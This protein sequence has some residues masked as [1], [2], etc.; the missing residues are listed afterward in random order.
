MFFQKRGRLSNNLK[1]YYNN[2]EIEI[3]SKFTYLGIVSST[4]GSF[5]HAQ[6][7]LSGQALKGIF[8]MNK[9]LNK[10]TNLTVKH[11]IY[12]KYMTYMINLYTL[13]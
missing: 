1:F 4:G 2:L 10:F 8:K 9:Q 11:R 5:L 7:T 3:V 6:L 13:F 12:D